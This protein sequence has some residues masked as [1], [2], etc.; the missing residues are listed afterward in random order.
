MGANPDEIERQINEQRARINDRMQGLEYRI[1]EDVEK[2]RTEA[3]NR[4]SGT[5]DGVKGVFQ[6]DGPMKDHPVS[7]LAGALGVG[8]LM[9]MVSEGLTSGGGGSSSSRG[10]RSYENGRSSNGGGATS[11]LASLVSSVIGPAAATAQNELQDLVREGFSS[12]KSMTSNG[13]SSADVLRRNRDVGV[14]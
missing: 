9:G 4:T 2:V 8:V 10:N 7:M 11:G 13:N 14:E 12:L 5:V 3:T 1:K 6:P